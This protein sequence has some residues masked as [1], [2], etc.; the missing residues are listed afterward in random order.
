MS[1]VTVQILQKCFP[2]GETCFGTITYLNKNIPNRWFVLI[3][4]QS[5]GGIT[6]GKFQGRREKANVLTVHTL[7]ENFTNWNGILLLNHKNETHSIKNDTKYL[8]EL[9]NISVNK[10]LLYSNKMIHAT[11]FEEY[12]TQNRNLLQSEKLPFYWTQ[13][14]ATTFVNK[15]LMYPF[16]K[17]DLNFQ[18]VFTNNIFALY[19]K[20]DGKVHTWIRF[21]SNG[22]IFTVSDHNSLITFMILFYGRNFQLIKW[23]K[24]C[25]SGFHIRNLSVL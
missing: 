6:V 20:E 15:V 8:I 2:F 17:I 23:I 4:L 16:I 9:W 14:F 25:P 7:S 11:V 3:C 5:M 10:I 12:A 19:Q 21:R 13:I 18:R 22:E 1:P 24:Q